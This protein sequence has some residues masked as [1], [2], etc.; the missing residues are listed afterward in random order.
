MAEPEPRFASLSLEEIDEL[1]FAKDS[2]SSKTATE[3]SFRTFLR[4][5]KEK[6]IIMDIYKIDPSELN[7]VLSR[8]YAEARKEDGSLYKKTSMP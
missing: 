2:I 7:E 5:C 3:V 4:Y 6:N 1:V 8:F